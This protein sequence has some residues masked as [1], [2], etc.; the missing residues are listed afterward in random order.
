MHSLLHM[1][2]TV[3]KK[4]KNSMCLDGNIAKNSKKR[5]KNVEKKLKKPRAFS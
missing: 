1:R 5:A 2:V 4:V 3:H